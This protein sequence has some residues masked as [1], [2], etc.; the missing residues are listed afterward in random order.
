MLEELKSQLKQV[1]GFPGKV[2]A[3]LQPQRDSISV[4]LRKMLRQLG[5]DLDKSQ[6]LPEIVAQVREKNPSLSRLLLNLDAATYDTRKQLS[7]NAHMLSA[8]AYMK[9]EQA[10]VRDLRPLFQSYRDTAQWRLRWLAGKTGQ[11][12]EEAKS[13]AETDSTSE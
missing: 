1:S 3:R 4:E 8:F 13:P 9:A 6:S 2:G 11:H 7:W 5:A 12:H 10:Y